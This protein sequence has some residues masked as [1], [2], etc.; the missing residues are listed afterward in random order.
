MIYL[1]V[2]VVGLACLS[3]LVDT[4]KDLSYAVSLLRTG[5]RIGV[6][7]NSVDPLTSLASSCALACCTVVEC[8]SACLEAGLEYVLSAASYAV[9]AESVNHVSACLCSANGG[10]SLANVES[11]ECPRGL[12]NDSSAVL[13][14]DKSE[15]GILNGELLGIP[16]A[17]SVACVL[18]V[19]ELVEGSTNAILRLVVVHSP[20]GE[21]ESVGTDVDKGTAALLILVNKYAPCRN[22]SSTKRCCL[23]VVNITE[24]AF[25]SLA[26]EV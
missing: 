20:E 9:D 19:V 8:N 26:L 13:H 23:C 21:V 11:V 24:R 3:G 6:V 12:K 7:D 14:Y 4:L 2:E 10:L 22:C 25:L 15:S 16:V 5:D 18:I 17:P 1:S